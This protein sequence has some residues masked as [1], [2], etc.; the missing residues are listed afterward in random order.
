MKDP[1]LKYSIEKFIE[2]VQG[3]INRMYATQYKKLTPKKL[4]V[5]ENRKYVKILS[6]GASW[7]FISKFDG[8][9]KGVP[10]KRGDLMFSAGQSPAKHSRGNIINGTARYSEY[11]PM[12]LK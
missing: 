5:I 2:E 3:K 7:G 11:G 10:V 6:D 9:N 4:V 1:Q 12:Y 8:M